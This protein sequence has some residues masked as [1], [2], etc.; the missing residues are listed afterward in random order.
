MSVEEFDRS[1]ISRL[2]PSPVVARL[3]TTSTS[4]RPVRPYDHS[5]PFSPSEFLI[6]APGS[7]S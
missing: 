1:Q 2:Y 4:P 5:S 3:W 6:R 7:C